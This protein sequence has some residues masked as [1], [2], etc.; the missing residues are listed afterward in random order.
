[1]AKRYLLNLFKIFVF[2][3]LLFFLCRA[4]YLLYFAGQIRHMG[5][6]IFLLSFYKAFPLDVSA[7][8]YLLIPAVFVLL[9]SNFFFTKI[10][11]STL[12]FYLFAT[13]LFC[14]LL[15]MGEIGVYQEVHTKMYF[16]MLTHLQHT[17]ELFHSISFTLMF[18][19]LSLVGLL[20]YISSILLKKLLP[21]DASPKKS[22]AQID[23][24]KISGSA[25]LVLAL[26]VIG[27]NGGLRKVAITG[28]DV[29]FS[30]DQCVNDATVNPM[31]NMGHSYIETQRTLHGEAYKFLP[32][33]EAKEA[34]N[35]LFSVEKDTTIQLFKVKR[36]NVC[37]LILESWSADLVESLGG[38]K[39]LTPNF[40]KL[41]SNGYLFTH[42]KPAGHV[43]DQGVPAVL[44]AYPALPIGSAIN[45]PKHPVHLANINNQLSANGYYSSFFFGGHLIYGN[46]KTYIDQNGFNRVIEQQDL[47]PTVPSGRLGIHDS[48]MLCIW[49]DSMNTYRQPFLTGLF[50]LST[51][52]P[53]DAISSPTINWGGCH[54]E[55]LSTAVY[56]DRQL[57]KFFED[58]KKEK[59]YDSTIFII[60]ADHSH[61]VPKDYPYESPEFYHIP[62]LIYGG[63]LKD[64]FRGAKY[65]H[66]A[67]QTD[68]AATL[69]HQLGYSSQPY[70][71][72]K[73]LMNPYS[74]QFAFYS[75]D[76]GFGFVDSSGLVIWNNK[77]PSENR[78]TGKTEKDK[79]ALYKNGAAMMQVLIKDFLS[80]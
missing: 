5:L 67:S 51:H 46:I 57:G 47:P 73:N 21:T 23:T 72:S 36:P 69:L 33:D 34:V 31:W 70:R 43:S 1:M 63:A 10:L 75:F 18:S 35:K 64:E 58:I 4:V 68:I 60:V 76:E 2:Y 37:V 17:D 79:T 74:Q 11:M 20:G 48:M 9:L 29:Y 55:Y 27:C 61:A 8:C 14:A 77:F 80:K 7:A 16:N 6:G 25:L 32:D 65:E 28:G 24:L 44:S 66:W 19:L 38:Y 15:S 42:V 12:R 59:W 26:L 50:T 71:W 56:A 62:L 3:L 45:Q 54:N 41:I 30:D 52:A 39:G 53:F 22:F 13:A 40:E 78:N 49:H